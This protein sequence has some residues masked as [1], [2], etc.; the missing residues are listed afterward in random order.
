MLG[1]VVVFSS[2]NGKSYVVILISFEGGV[3]ARVLQVGDHAFGE[4]MFKVLVGHAN[5]HVL[6]RMHA[7]RGRV[8]R[9]LAAG[10]RVIGVVVY[11]H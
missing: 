8:M 11:G 7:Y 4:I 1:L 2:L 10:D 5:P 6:V 9:S 3:E